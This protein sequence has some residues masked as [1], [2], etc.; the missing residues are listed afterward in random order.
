[1]Q[2]VKLTYIIRAVARRAVEHAEE[3]TE[4]RQKHRLRSSDPGREAGEQVSEVVGERFAGVA[5]PRRSVSR[6]SAAQSGASVGA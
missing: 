4:C 5:V 3:W 6:A 2:Y 1:M